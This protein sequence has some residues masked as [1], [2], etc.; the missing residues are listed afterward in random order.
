MLSRQNHG[1]LIK[2]CHDFGTSQIHGIKIATCLWVEAKWLCLYLFI[3]TGGF[4]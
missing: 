3:Q 1:G 2:I 4:S